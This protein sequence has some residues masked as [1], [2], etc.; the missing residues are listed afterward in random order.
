MR[1]KYI[2]I[3]CWCK[4]LRKSNDDTCEMIN[5]YFRS[6]GMKV[7]GHGYILT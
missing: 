5:A 1:I 2:L 6:C 7:V 4:L 3:K